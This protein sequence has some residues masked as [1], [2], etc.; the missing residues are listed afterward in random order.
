MVLMLAVVLMLSVGIGVSLQWVET[1][2]VAIRRAEASFV[3]EES[4]IAAIRIAS[5]EIGWEPD[6]QSWAGGRYQINNLEVDVFCHDIDQQVYLHAE[7]VSGT[8]WLQAE[9][10]PGAVV[11]ERWRLIRWAWTTEEL[12]VCSGSD[13]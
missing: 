13:C 4:M 6:C 1:G 12:A 9:V 11:G 2:I 5:V 8:R 7:I 10:Q 3:A